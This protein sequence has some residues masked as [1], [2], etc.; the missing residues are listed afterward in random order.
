MDL[1]L[2]KWDSP[3]DYCEIYLMPSVR[4]FILLICP[5]S[6]REIISTQVGRK[7]SEREA[8]VESIEL[9][10]LACS[11]LIIFALFASQHLQV[12]FSAESER[13]AL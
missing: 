13:M 8:R 3:A 10:F 2:F 4:L 9:L 11:A 6:R 1:C 12:G 5:G 7:R